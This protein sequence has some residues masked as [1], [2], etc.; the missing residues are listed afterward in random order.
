MNFFFRT[1]MNLSDAKKIF[2]EEF[3]RVGPNGA[4]YVTTVLQFI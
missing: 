4:P 1:E 3:F 2:R